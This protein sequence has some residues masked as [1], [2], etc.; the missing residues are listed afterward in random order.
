MDAIGFESSEAPIS[1]VALLVVMTKNA[2]MVLTG[3]RMAGFLMFFISLNMI[4]QSYKNGSCYDED[5]AIGSDC[6]GAGRARDGTGCGI[7]PDGIV[8]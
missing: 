1:A 4:W 6:F 8:L 5:V 7:N 2:A 3:W